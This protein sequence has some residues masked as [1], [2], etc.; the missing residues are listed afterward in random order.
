MKKFVF[1]LLALVLLCVSATAF[2]SSLSASWNDGKLTITAHFD[3]A[4]GAV[5]L[6]GEGIGNG[7]SLT[8][9]Q[10]SITISYPADNKSHT[11]SC[12]PFTGLP[13]GFSDSASFFAGEKGAE[14]TATPAP[15]PYP[16][17]HCYPRTHCYRDPGTH[18]YPRTH[19]HP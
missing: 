14:P 1:V 13:G 4:Q 5:A 19:C 6:S 2:A 10:P 8:V 16:G 12:S 7:R 9:D 15:P 18:C 3:A 17:T 11:V